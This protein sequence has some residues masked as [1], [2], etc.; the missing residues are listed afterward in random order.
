MVIP[1]TLGTTTEFTG[2]IPALTSITLNTGAI[3]QDGRAPARNGAVT[4]DSNLID[5]EE[6]RNSG[7]DVIPEAS[8][9]TLFASL[10]A[11]GLS[12][13]GMA[14]RRRRAK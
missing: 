8:T 14:A 5:C 11:Y 13:L 3:I 4:L 6:C 1:A 9:V 12:F 7:P 2:N 10:G